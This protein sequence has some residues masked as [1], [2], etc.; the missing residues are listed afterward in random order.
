MVKTDRDVK[1][2]A[3]LYV[4]ELEKLGVSV[5]EIRLFGSYAR[6]EARSFSDIDF[7]VVSS[8]FGQKDRLELS[9][10]LSRAAFPLDAI[11]EAIGI[12]PEKFESAP[13]GSFYEHIRKT[14]KVVYKKA[15]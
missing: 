1:K 3:A 15:A 10:V 2:I 5:D 4:R 9:G 8:R 13:K 14:G 11:I 7:I 12:S 6:G